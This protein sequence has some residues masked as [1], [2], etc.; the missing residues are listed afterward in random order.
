MNFLDFLLLLISIAALNFLVFFLF[1]IF[2]LK[3]Q[4]PAMKFLGLNL[5]KDVFWCAVWLYILPKEKPV[6]FTLV[7]V[8]LVASFVLYYYVIRSINK[9]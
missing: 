6:F 2:V 1:K 9:L 5:I 8:F 4:N 7:S 3:I